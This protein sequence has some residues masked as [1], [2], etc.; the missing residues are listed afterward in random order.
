MS[1]S[2][3]KSVTAASPLCGLF[4]SLRLIFL[5]HYYLTITRLNHQRVRS[6]SSKIEC[7]FL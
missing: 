3:R 5:P 1:R 4:L 2:E 6:F 7:K